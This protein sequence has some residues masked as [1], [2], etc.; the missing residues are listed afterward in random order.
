MKKMFEK[1][2][3]EFLKEVGLHS[4]ENST[5]LILCIKCHGY[6]CRKKMPNIHVN[7]GLHLDPIPNELK[8]SDLEQQLIARSLIFLK[9]KRLP[10]TR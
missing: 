9:V 7:N 3:R 1:L 6:I 5:D 10:K 4:K 2:D 8:L